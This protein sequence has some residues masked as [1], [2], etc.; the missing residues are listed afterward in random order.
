[1]F[2]KN[3]MTAL[4]ITYALACGGVILW[5]FL[6]LLSVALVSL[7]SVVICLIFTLILCFL[8]GLAVFPLIAVAS[9]CLALGIATLIFVGQKLAKRV[10]PSRAV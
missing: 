9:S 10:K 7:G 6:A 5:V 8:V 1:M 3:F 2:E 4:N